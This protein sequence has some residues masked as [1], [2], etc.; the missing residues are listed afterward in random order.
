MVRRRGL[1]KQQGRSSGYGWVGFWGGWE[2]GMGGWVAVTVEGRGGRGA[3]MALPLYRLPGTAGGNSSKLS[4]ETVAITAESFG[5][6]VQDYT[7]LRGTL[8]GGRNG[9]R[10]QH[11]WGVTRTGI[12]GK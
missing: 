5:E 8:L 1:I 12:M 11:C 10:R 4:E 7:Q 9:R 3:G 2:D 6:A